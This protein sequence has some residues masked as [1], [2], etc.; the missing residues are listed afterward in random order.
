MTGFAEQS[1]FTR[2]FK[3]WAGQTPRS[4]R[5]ESRLPETTPDGGDWRDAS[6][7]W[8]P[9]SRSVSPGPIACVCRHRAD[10]D[11]PNDTTRQGAS[12]GNSQET[13]Q[14]P[15]LTLVTGGTGK[16]GRRVAAGLKARGVP[17]RIGS[18][19]AVPAFDWT[20]DASW[21]ACLEGAE[22]AY[23]SYAPDLAVPGH[24]RHPGLRRPAEAPRR[25]AAGPALG[26]RRGGSPG[27]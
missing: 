15:G 12:H 22:A 2:A 21:D 11:R 27:L 17:V 1:S 6:K 19:S 7:S 14:A 4:Y 25:P 24:R 3:R 9:A 26:S 20:R 16:T 13:T 5:L 23:I 18:R 10:P 8:R